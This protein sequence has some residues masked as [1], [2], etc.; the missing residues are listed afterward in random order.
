MPDDEPADAPAA[1]EEADDTDDEL[2]DVLDDDVLDD[3][4][5]GLDGDDDD[6]S[7]LIARRARAR[8]I[9]EAIAGVVNR[10]PGRPLSPREFTDRDVDRPR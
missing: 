9:E 10:E 1:L 4:V 6:A 5:L 3:D 2:D 7:D 8:L